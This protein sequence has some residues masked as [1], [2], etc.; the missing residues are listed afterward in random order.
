[1]LAACSSREAELLKSAQETVAAI[2]AGQLPSVRFW[3]PEYRER[4]K[5]ALETYSPQK[6][7]TVFGETKK[8]I[9]GSALRSPFCA[10]WHILTIFPSPTIRG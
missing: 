3:G 5:L 7:E 8:T 4:Q 9:L 10:A 1:V 2:D 6:A